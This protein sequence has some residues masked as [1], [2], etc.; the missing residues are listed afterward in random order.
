MN[1]R[2][3]AEVFSPGEYLND[4]LQA[5]GWSQVDFADII[6]RPA[7]VVNQ[8]IAGKRS[9]TP[10]IAKLIAAALGTSPM[11]WLNLE[12]AYRL[13]ADETPVSNRIAR[14][15]RLRGRFAVREMAKRGWIE[16]SQDPTE[17]EQQ[18][19][20]F[21]G[22]SDID[23]APRLAHAAKKTAKIGYP[24][25]LNAGQRAWLFRVKQIAA[26]MPVATY[27]ESAL[28]AAIHE[29]RTLLLSPE[30]V[31][32]VP[33]ILA[34]C[35]ARFVIVEH[36]ASSKIDGVTFWLDGK[37]P[38]IGMSLRLDKIDNFWFVLR[39]E[40]EHVLNKHGREEAIIDVDSDKPPVNVNQ[41][42]RIANDAAANFCVPADQMSD[43]IL[44]NNPLF[45]EEKV[46]NFA[47][48]MQVHPGVVVG[49]LQRR[50][51]RWKLFHSHLAKIRHLVA[52]IAMTDGYGQ[53]V[54]VV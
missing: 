17:L 51:G 42:E 40:I 23:E 26:K 8:I 34:E 50:T 37:S 29:L 28:R 19:L 49:Q 2:A 9:I 1:E 32:Q 11:V 25:D 7:P 54:P 39:H 10:E 12:A 48:R 43:F 52:P 35:G 14:H 15:A 4:E 46:L 21:F 5:R 31:M 20:K 30:G 22:I 3:P 18:V 33:K 36:V 38:V 45:S 44:R 47:W 6:G 53:I 27:S 16:G 41:E 13:H 24:E